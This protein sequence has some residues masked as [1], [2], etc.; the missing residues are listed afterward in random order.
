[1]RTGSPFA[2]QKERN[3]RNI[4]INKSGRRQ[5]SKKTKKKKGRERKI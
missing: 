3:D 1:M 2:G 4:N 5:N